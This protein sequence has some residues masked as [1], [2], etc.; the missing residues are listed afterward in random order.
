MIPQP[1]KDNTAT[2]IIGLVI[3]LIIAV[4]AY[5]LL[6]PPAPVEEKDEQWV[7][8]GASVISPNATA[9]IVLSEQC[10]DCGYVDD[11]ID[12]IKEESGNLGTVIT[13]VET[14]YDSSSE[15]RTLVTKYNIASLPTLILK[16]EGQWDSRMLTLWLSEIGS[17]EDDST[18]VYR[19]VVPPYYDRTTKSVRGKMEFIYITDSGCEEC[20]NVSEF[21]Q[22]MVRVFGMELEKITE[23]DV[24]SVE[25]N[26][27]VNQY[28]IT[29]VPT[30]LASGEAEVY[31]GFDDFWFRFDSTKEDD[32]WYVFRDVDKIGVVY[33]TVNA[34]ESE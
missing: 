29:M 31:K 15:G 33:S 4:G 20:Y 8:E 30:F 13:E 5:V 32:G 27:I 12:R 9:T 19:N 3:I 17:I 24:T 2:M 7:A 1:Q 28:G 34:T 11:L 21:A 18:L 14:V 6:T 25:G 26:A 23:Y 22:D 16:K 10:P